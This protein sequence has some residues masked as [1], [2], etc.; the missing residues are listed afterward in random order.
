MR[1]L[2]L[3]MDSLMVEAFETGRADGSRGTVR[4]NESGTGG[5]WLCPADTTSDAPT[6]YVVQTCAL[7]GLGC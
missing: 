6:C 4:A 3:D 5:P 2:K 7:P 1:K